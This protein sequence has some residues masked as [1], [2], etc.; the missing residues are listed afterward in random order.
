MIATAPELDLTTIDFSNVLAGIDEIRALNPHRHE[1]EM[2][3]A[4][5][6]ID[7]SRH[8]I[9]GYKDVTDKE[10]WVRGHMPGFP[11]MPGVLMC[12]AAA[13][14]CCYYYV[15]QKIGD[16]GVLLGLGGL[17][18]TR[19]LRQ[20]RPGDRLVMVGN[21]VKVHRRMTKI[22]VVGTVNGDKAFET[23]VTG[24]PIGK[25]EELRGA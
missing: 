10:Y 11:L 4:V 15:S 6:H 5:V 13:Q 23:I 3:T 19:F 12:E 20:V 17:D 24:V 7:P 16:P 9:V 14:L 1:F 2:L 8:V 18:E 21:G 25:L 22:R